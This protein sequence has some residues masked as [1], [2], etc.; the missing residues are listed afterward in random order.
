MPKNPNSIVVELEGGLGNQL[1][2]WATGLSLAKRLKLELK[3]DSSNLITRK[4]A[5]D[6]FDLT[7]RLEIYSKP[8]SKKYKLFANQQIF[9][10]QDFKY[11][12]RIRSISKGVTLKGYFQSW[13]YFSDISTEIR[14]LVTLRDESGQLKSVRREFR[15]KEILAVHVRRG[16][17]VGLEN[18]HGTTTELY[19]E[20]S[21]KIMNNLNN[22]STIV[23]FSDDITAAKVAVPYAD[24]YISENEIESPGETMI[25]MSECTALIGSNSS[26]SWWAGYLS[27]DDSK[28][29]IFPRP[30]FTDDALDTRDLLPN[31]W[32]TLGL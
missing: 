13:K 23:V 18:H 6:S 3:L 19:Y 10:E 32:L 27:D 8:K 17:Y 25:L 15:N 5:L 2:G 22:F 7:D 11:D 26:F 14:Q 28:S 24:Y 1:F 9:Q 4:L 16:D 30:W 21:I 12:S 20:K 31:N 29:R